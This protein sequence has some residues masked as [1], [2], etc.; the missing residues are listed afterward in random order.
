MT[1]ARRLHEPSIRPLQR[2]VEN[3]AIGAGLT[4]TPDVYLVDDLGAERVRQR[5]T[6]PEKSFVGVTTGLLQTMPKRELEAVIGTRSRTFVT[7]TPT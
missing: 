6:R 2:V 3:V 1:G 7:A 4:V 5:A